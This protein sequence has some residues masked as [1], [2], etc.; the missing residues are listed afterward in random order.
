MINRAL[1]VIFAFLLAIGMLSSCTSTS[2]YDAQLD[3]WIGKNEK[4][5]A[6]SWGAPDRQS[7]IDAETKTVSYDKHITITYPDNPSNCTETVNRM[8][9]MQ[10]PA[11]G[12]FSPASSDY[13]CETTFTLVKGVVT[14][15]Q[16]EGNNCRS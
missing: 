9:E 11:C 16:H 13:V 7:R 2:N 14:R 8:G 1:S 12:S 3:T 10:T 4:D 15:W 5:L 6:A